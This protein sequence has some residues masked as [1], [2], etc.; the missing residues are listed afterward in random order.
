MGVESYEFEETVRF[1]E[2]EPGDETI[3][4][5]DPDFRVGKTVAEIYDGCVFEVNKSGSVARLDLLELEMAE[6][7]DGALLSDDL[8]PDYGHALVALARLGEGEAIPSTHVIDASFSSMNERMVAGL[9]TSIQRGVE[10][11]WQGKREILYILAEEIGAALET[12]TGAR[13]DHLESALVF[14]VGGLL[15][16]GNELSPRLEVDP[17]I[18]SRAEAE[19][20]AF[21]QRAA[22]STPSGLYAWSDTLEEVYRQDRFLE[23]RLVEDDTSTEQIGRFAAIAAVMESGDATGLLSGYLKMIS[24]YEGLRNPNGSYTPIDLLA[25]VDG[26]GSLDDVAAIA[27]S[28][29]ADHPVP[30]ECEGS[31]LA[32]FPAPKGKLGSYIDEQLCDR[33]TT[34]G[35]LVRQMVI[36]AAQQGELDLEPDQFSGWADYDVHAEEALWLPNRGPESDHLLVTAAYKDRSPAISD[37]RTI[38]RKVEQAKQSTSWGGTVEKPQQ[39][40]VYPKLP[41]EPFST[42]YLR[43]ARGYRFLRAHLSA[44]LGDE[45]LSSIYAVSPGGET[46]LAAQLDEAVV[47]SYGLYLET[48]RSVGLEGDAFLTAVELEELDLA[49]C[50]VK[51]QLW[52]DGWQT[53]GD[54]LADP[55][56]LELVA[57]D[58]QAGVDIYW[59]VLGVRAYRVYSEYVE[60]YEP[61]FEPKDSDDCELREIVSRDYYLLFEEEREIRIARSHGRLTREELREVGDRHDD[62]ED[63]VA[64][65]EGLR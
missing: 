26:L 12:A 36:E 55:R 32:L 22:L 24:L 50:S 7:T 6:S 51:A 49:E 30:Y 58:D 20:T 2:P 34:A 56:S 18:V 16:G 11:L 31:Y 61:G 8:Y 35:E 38:R 63:M 17:L 39:T 47:R 25:Y 9:E 10:G 43:T 41:A 3:E 4:D 28:F 33:P 46:S 60:G 19:V 62:V 44:V 48:A 65:L 23:N 45:L 54:V 64:E 13:V 27:D 59:A 5:K 21:D 15:A 37:I 29:V 57:R 14:V 52:L 1:R 53:D 42:Y 40:D